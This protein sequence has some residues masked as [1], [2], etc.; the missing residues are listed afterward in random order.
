MADLV[1]TLRQ[2]RSRLAQLIDFPV[3][4]A[5]LRRINI[6]SGL[7]AISSTLRDCRWNGR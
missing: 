7:V 4:P 3:L 1:D 6:L 5:I 2:R